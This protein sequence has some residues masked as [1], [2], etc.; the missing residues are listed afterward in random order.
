VVLEVEALLAG[1]WTEAPLDLA[2][3]PPPGPRL[4]AGAGWELVDGDERIPLAGLPPGKG[5]VLSAD[6]QRVAVSDG[7]S[8][9]VWSRRSGVELRV[10]IDDPRALALSTDGA[11]LA[12]A[13]VLGVDIVDLATRQARRV[14]SVRVEDLAFSP[15]GQWLAAGSTPMLIDV[16]SGRIRFDAARDTFAEVAD[17]EVSPDGRRVAVVDG[18]GAV[19]LWELGTGRRRWRS[20]PLGQ[21]VATFRTDGAVEASASLGQVRF[22]EDGRIQLVRGSVEPAVL[23]VDD[24]GE[25]RVLDHRLGWMRWD[26][27]SGLP[28]SLAPA[29]SSHL[30]WGELLGVVDHVRWVVPGF[31]GGLAPGVPPCS[32]GGA[33]LS[34]ST[35]PA[36]QVPVVTAGLATTPS[37]G[38][39]RDLLPSPGGTYLFGILDDEDGDWV[40]RGPNG[41]QAVLPLPS[42]ASVAWAGPATAVA[43][44]RGAVWRI[45]ADGR[46]VRTRAAHQAPVDAVAAAGD[47]MARWVPGA[48]LVGPA[49]SDE[50][51]CVLPRAGMSSG[52]VFSP[53]GRW[54]AWP[55]VGAGVAVA[56]VDACRRVPGPGLPLWTGSGRAGVPL[57]QGL[58]VDSRNRHLVGSGRDAPRWDTTALGRVVAAGAGPDGTAVVATADGL[59]HVVDLASLPAGRV[60]DRPARR[61]QGGIGGMGRRTPSGG[62]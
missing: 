8:V 11:L 15:G 4:V 39:E 33:S 56:D 29:P 55:E 34:C 12:V 13:S 26:A 32:A 61:G 14:V 51:A 19:S 44:A 21:G 53:D 27:A 54:L 60:P 37:S 24:S 18:R 42:Q 3:L 10:P 1:T 31:I 46:T 43:A 17:L 49:G 30:G 50:V 45:G 22:D 6:G 7:D 2:A 47:R 23:A 28:V 9:W 38:R 59:L 35:V 48:V 57:G 52:G 62:R 36:G 41:A 58:R 20:E 25:V 40:V 5:G 16:A